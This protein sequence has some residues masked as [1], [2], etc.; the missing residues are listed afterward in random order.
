MAWRFGRAAPPP[1]RPA[2][3][4][5]RAVL[6][7]RR[8]L[9]ADLVILIALVLVPASI[10]NVHL[11]Y[12]TVRDERAALY[13]AARQQARETA[14]RADEL[15]RETRGLLAGLA[16]TPTVREGDRDQVRTLLRDVRSGFPYLDDLLL[17]APDG[18]VLASAAGPPGEALSADRGEALRSALAAGQAG[19]GRIVIS[20]ATNRPVAVIGRTVHA[21]GPGE[22]PIGAVVATLDLTRLQQWLDTRPLG[23]GATITVVDNQQGRVLAR[24]LDPEAW[25]GRDLADVPVVRAAIARDEGI[26]E[27]ASVVGLARLN[28]FATAREMPWTVM[29]GIPREAIDAPV[30]QEIRLILARLLLAVIATVILALLAV[31]WIA[32]PLR[33]LTASAGTIAGGDLAHRA[34]VPRHEEVARL[35]I[36]MNRMADGLVGSLDS[37]RRA[38]ERLEGAIAE[39]GRAL[40]SA[41]EPSGVLT[42]LV[43]AAV[44]LARADAGLL[45]FA[46]ASPPV[47]G[48]RLP[49]PTPGVVAA[50]ARHCDEADRGEVAAREAM[51][52]VLGMRR[53]LAVDVR[54]RGKPLGLLMVFRE[55]LRD[56][57]AT[58]ER[59]LRTFAA[60]AAVAIEQARLRGE[61]AKAEA[62]RELHRLQ[63]EFLTAASHELR[64]PITGIMGYADMLLRDDLGLDPETRRSCLGG[65]RRQ[66]ER[67]SE[68]VRAYFNA[69]RIGERQLALRR[70]PVDLAPLAAAVIE[71]FAVRSPHHALT[72]TAAP[73]LPPV[74]ADRERIDDVLTNL[75]DNA[76]KY[77]PAGG[78]IVVEL[79][80]SA[81]A[82]AGQR[83]LVVATVRDR[84]I[85]IP[86]AERE[87][88]FERFYRIDHHPSRQASGVGLGLY[89]CRAYVEG[90]GGRIWVANE[91]DTGSSLRFTL[92][93]APAQA[94]GS[95]PEPRGGAA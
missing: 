74:L 44:A 60:Q 20:Q 85:G 31:R 95:G 77:S 55:E 39:V 79:A 28:G 93:A 69:M 13:E 12:V 43:E 54:A 67:L 62:L 7:R 19:G 17:V 11:S 75:L 94:A 36:A 26:V 35:G 6:G 42:P 72:L 14:H 8:S 64:A 29:V 22:E 71:S 9:V 68:Q 21:A 18:A 25:I 1:D 87:R 51:A 15:V 63:S 2:T 83:S 52:A 81:E 30:I 40:T 10:L 66:A 80:A 46:D 56:F 89:L 57:D 45:A 38:Q 70:E 48:G 91:P 65:I 49:T 47:P 53:C 4:Q 78:P 24:S 41:G 76:I 34:A 3:E 50:L 23:A 61:V 59:L 88:I 92:P 86:P 33:Q 37:T 73:D 84:G 90:M 58:D 32:H 5:G 82:G 27:D 16:E